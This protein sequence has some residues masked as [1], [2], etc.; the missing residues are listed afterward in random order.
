MQLLIDVKHFVAAPQSFNSGGYSSDLEVVGL[1]LSKMSSRVLIQLL[2]CMDM[3]RI[4][5]Q[6]T[7]KSRMGYLGLHASDCCVKDSQIHGVRCALSDIEY[8]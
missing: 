5:V 4:N 8:F 7:V 1:K 2:H 3:A 6:Q